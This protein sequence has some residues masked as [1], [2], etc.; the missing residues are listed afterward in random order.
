[1]A[2]IHSLGHCGTWLLV[3]WKVRIKNL[4]SSAHS[5]LIIYPSVAIMVPWTLDH[6]VFAWYGHFVGSD[7]PLT[8]DRGSFVADFRYVL[9]VSSVNSK[10]RSLNKR[11]ALQS[12]L[13]VELVSQSHEI[14]MN[15][16]ITSISINKILKNYKIL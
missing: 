2:E 8:A 14:I 11:I 3:M 10:P 6:R 7:E 12:W 5:A 1:M 16:F 9:V 15:F 4:N 13:A